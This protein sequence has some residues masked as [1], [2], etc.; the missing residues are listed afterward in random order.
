MRQ[1]I[2]HLNGAITKCWF[3]AFRQKFW[4]REL[5]KITINVLPVQFKYLPYCRGKILKFNMSAKIPEGQNC[6][7]CPC[8]CLCL[9]LCLFLCF[10]T[11]YQRYLSPHWPRCQDQ[12]DDDQLNPPRHA[13]RHAGWQILWKKCW[14]WFI[15]ICVL[16]SCGN[17][18]SS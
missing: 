4:M 10:C 18:K 5:Q 6:H 17:I 12:C 7:L 15:S 11:F 14:I 2:E 8:P 9:F 16:F 1:S 3:D 13:C